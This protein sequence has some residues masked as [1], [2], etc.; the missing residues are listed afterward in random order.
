MQAAARRRR[1]R[2]LAAA[3]CGLV[4]AVL[5]VAAIVWVNLD[6][7]QKAAKD[8]AEAQN[9]M[10]WAD[11]SLDAANDEQNALGGIV[12]THDPRYLTPFEEGRQRFEHSFER[13]SAYSLD[14]P[15]DQRQAVATAR[16]LARAWTL[17]VAQPQVAATKAGRTLPAPSRAALDG[18]TQV[19]RSIDD[20]RDGETRLLAQR[21]HVLA[22][23]YDTTRTAMIAGSTAALAFVLVILGLAARQLINDQRQ[24]EEAA[25]GLGKALERAQAA[26]RAKSRFLANMSHE[27]RTPLNGVAGMT[28]AL[29]CTRLDPAQRELID[30]IGFSA[31]TLDH[32]IG[33]LISVSRDGVAARAKHEAKTFRLGAAIRAM[34]LPFDAEAQAK[35]VAFSVEVEPAADIEVTG[36]AGSLGELLACLLS[37][38]VKFTESG[39][40]SVGVRRL[41][42]T[43][44]GVEVRDTGPGFDAARQA[45]MFETFSQEDDSDTRR[46]GGAGLGLAVARRLAEELGGT[47]EAQSTPGDGAVFSLTCDLA[48]ASTDA[49]PAAAQ[50]SAPV[51][52]EADESP[53]V[54]IVDDNATNRRVLELILEQFGVDWVSVEDGQ[55]AVDAA[56]AQ[57]FTAILMDIQMPVMDGLTATREIR[58]IEREA[59]RPAAPG[60]H[61]L[62]QLRARACRGRPR[63]RRPE[64]PK[65][66]RQRPDPDRG[67]Q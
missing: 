65:Q 59:D 28:Q 31:S 6:L 51:A 1:L 13:L 57:A 44:F 2:Y 5:V 29:A 45:R 61:R 47:L 12:A 43:T 3:F 58:R 15:L 21:E 10:T 4:A 49:A 25:R 35:G 27:M 18:M 17:G 8:V 41:G 42:E 38:A 20:L 19:G 40:V 53:R 48:V 7:I 54:L 55:Q 26:E 64:P 16:R 23:A 14:D 24:A 33:D 66:A 36:D 46:F 32:L 62:G 34:A 37:N 63:C 9:E 52:E 60:D 30:A 50:A 67:P 56:R 39:K 22:H 11:A